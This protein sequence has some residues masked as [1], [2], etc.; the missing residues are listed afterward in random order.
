[1]LK[2]VLKKAEELGFQA[3]TACEFEFLVVEET[4]KSLSDKRYRN[5]SPLGVGNFGYSVIR[6]SVNTPF[7]HGMLDLFEDMRIPIEGLHEETGP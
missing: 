7:Y 5:L 3:K 2:R 4:A 1:V 6:N